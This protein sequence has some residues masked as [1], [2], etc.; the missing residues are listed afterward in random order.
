M[1]CSCPW[2]RD[3]PPPPCHQPMHPPIQLLQWDI[4]IASHQSLEMPARPG[5]KFLSG[6]P[7]CRMNQIVVAETYRF[8]FIPGNQA[9]PSRKLV[10]VSVSIHLGTSCPMLA[11][12]G[13]STIPALF[14]I[15]IHLT[16]YFREQ[17]IYINTWRYAHSGPQGH[18]QAMSL[19]SLR[20]SAIHVSICWL[21]ICSAATRN[22]SPPMRNT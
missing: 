13:L 21:E 14:F 16:V 19:N 3:E 12:S 4:C 15:L 18:T 11:A 7:S 22:S 2:H 5:I 1:H 17:I 6:L 9:H 20:Y 10:I 8:L